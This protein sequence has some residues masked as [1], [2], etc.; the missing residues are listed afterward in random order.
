MIGDIS[1]AEW[2]ATVDPETGREVVQLTSARANSYPLYYFVPSVTAD[3]RY[4]VLHSERTGTVQLHRLDLATGEL[5]QL[6]DGSTWDAGWAV[7]CV[8]RLRGIYGHLSAL[9]PV[10]DEVYYCQDD[11]IR[12]SSV[13]TFADRLVARLPEGRMPIAQN[14][15]SPDGR[16]LAIVHVD[17]REYTRRLREREVAENMGRFD[18]GRD[19]HR[20]FRN[21]LETALDVVDTATGELR[22]VITT[23]FHFHHVLWVDDRTIL[24]NHPKDVAGMWV[25]DV[26]GGNVRHLRPHTHPE[27]HSAVVNH[28]VVTAAGIAYEAVDYHDDGTRTNYLGRYHPADDTFTE[29]RLPV[30]GYVH[31]GFD[32][33]GELDLIEHASRDGHELLRVLPSETPGGDLR[34]ERIRRLASPYRE[35]QRSHAHPFLSPDRRW[36]LWTDWSSDGF[37]QVFRM[38]TDSLG[39]RA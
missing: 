18:W 26:D 12:A 33:A 11:E 17:A 37:S 13:S 2:I 14:A 34:V 10:G 25:V 32:P 38:S 1:P 16:L 31:V 19:H 3:G 15:V 5:G 28:Q 7:W 39:V 36:L 4:L 9:S 35:E 20:W 24:V 27:A 23:D 30:P 22:R 21:D 29:G 6:T 8:W